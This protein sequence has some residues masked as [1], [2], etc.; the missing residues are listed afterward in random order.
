[1]TTN[2]RFS[3]LRPLTPDEMHS[4]TIRIWNFF[5]ITNNREIRKQL[6][7]PIPDGAMQ[8]LSINNFMTYLKNIIQMPHAERYYSQITSLIRTMESKGVLVNAGHDV[9]A[10]G[11]NTCYYTMKEL[12][13]LQSEN[14][15]WLGS[16]LG[17]NYLR[18]KL[19]SYIVRI[20]GENP[21]RGSGTGSG[22]LISPS[23]ILTCGHNIKDMEIRSCWIGDTEL[24][25]E[26]MATHEK[27]D[28]GIIKISPTNAVNKFPY[29][30][31]P[32]ILDQ[33]LTLGYPPIRGIREPVL[34]AQT[35]EIN[36]IGT[37]FFSACE[38]ITISSITR[39]GNSGGPVF[40]LEGYIVGI[41]IQASTAV[42]AVGGDSSSENTQKFESP[43]YLAV[44]SNELP[45]IVSEID[46]DVVIRFEDYQ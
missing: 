9:S 3:V 10:P 20:E 40:S 17:A 35:G 12:T 15:F 8:P 28:I 45:R 38:C 43:F 30:G 11:R 6:S 5:A 46:S 34:L 22:I 14:D 41:V 16:I 25:I 32:Y 21:I 26:D 39:P 13:E 1:M 44:S 29:F 2:Q 31:P 18:K 33:T 24:N 36:A 4:L 7:L 37:E 42:D 23:T 27:Y 19:E